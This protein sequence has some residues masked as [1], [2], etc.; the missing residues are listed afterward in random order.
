MNFY[1]KKIQ[2]GYTVLATDTHHNIAYITKNH[3]QLQGLTI[4]DCLNYG[5][6]VPWN[7]GQL[8]EMKAYFIYRKRNTL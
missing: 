1:V 3:K 8:N 6:F 4:R 2:V 5:K 7:I